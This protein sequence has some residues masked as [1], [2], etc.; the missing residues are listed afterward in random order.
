MKH[1]SITARRPVFESLED[2]RLLT[3]D[4]TPLE[5]E[6]LQLTNRFRTDPANEYGR[7]IKADSPIQS[8][9]AEVTSNLSFFKVDSSLLRSEL[10]RVAPAPPLAWNE[11]I[12][13][14][15]TS[16]NGT[17]IAK[18]SQEHY[19]GLANALNALGVPIEAGTGQNA[20]YNNLGIGKTPFFVHSAY[21][22]DWGPGGSGGM[23]PNRGHRNNMANSLHNQ[24]G[25]PITPN[26]GS[27]VSTQFFAK[28]S[29]AQKMAV[30][31]VFEDKNKSG[32]YEAGEGIG[33]VQIAF[34]GTAGRFT[35]TSMTAGGYQVVLPAGTYSVTATGGSLKHA[36]TLPSVTVNSTNVWQNLIYDPTAI[37][38]DAREPNNSLTSAIPLVGRDQILTALSIHAGDVDYFRFTADGTGSATIILQFNNANGNI[39]LRLFD[40]TG[41]QLAASITSDAN[42]TITANLVRGQSYFVQVFS[43]TGATNAEYSLQMNLPEPAVPVAALDRGRTAQGAGTLTLSILA[44]DSDTDSDKA[45]LAPAIQTRGTGTFTINSDKTLSYSPPENYSGVD[46][47]TYIVTDDQGLSS[48]PAAVEV[49]V[50]NFASS[51]PWRNH[52]NAFDVNDDGSVTPL[53]ALLVINLLSARTVRTFP[54]TLSE[55]GSIFWFADTT[56]N[57]ELEPRD[58]LLVI[59]ELN[60]RRRGGGEGE[61]AV[62]A[63]VAQDT[64]LQQMYADDTDIEARKRRR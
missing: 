23:Q 41:T 1:S 10:S 45:L 42:E 48:R 61:R 47:A 17:M 9:D 49:L 2:R 27:L 33:G 30:G 5:Q 63:F 39:D 12:H 51:T 24:I 40:A 50:L 15:A 52:R 34:E 46:R 16:Q 31:A 35:T 59:N 21:V 55:S 20:F 44:N 37:P 3:L 6:M 8:P 25:S 7:L 60:R 18:N 32:W 13:D 36:I 54:R 53:D 19:P 29:S 64:A 58:V 11:V 28:V 43:S 57:N 26:A 22:I 14:L 4:P 62:E 38:P 56:G